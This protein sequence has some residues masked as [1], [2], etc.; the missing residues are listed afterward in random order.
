MRLRGSQRR[1]E[2]EMRGRRQ[3]KREEEGT[4][5]RRNIHKSSVPTRPTHPLESTS[6]PGLRTHRQD[7]TKPTPSQ[8]LS[9]AISPSN[10]PHPPG[11]PSLEQPDLNVFAGRER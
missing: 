6:L 11:S 7:L 1:E 9:K 2:E 4:G 3:T 10:T 5:T 8:C